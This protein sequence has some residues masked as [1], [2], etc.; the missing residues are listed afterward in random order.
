M[1]YFFKQHEENFKEWRNSGY[2]GIPQIGV[3]YLKHLGSRHFKPNL[4]LWNEKQWQ[5]AQGESQS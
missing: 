5:K 2:Q 1:H 3:D 4:K